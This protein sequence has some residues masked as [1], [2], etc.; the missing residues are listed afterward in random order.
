MKVFDLKYLTSAILLVLTF[1]YGVLSTHYQW[2]PYSYMLA[3][4]NH[5][6]PSTV[7][8]YAPS[9][10]YLEKKSL[11]ENYTN[12]HFDV[13]FIG[14]S[15]TD[16]GHWQEFFSDLKIAN[17]GIQGDMT[18]GVLERLDIIPAGSQSTV[19]LMIGINDLIRERPVDDVFR[20]YQSIVKD[21]VSK[22]VRVYIQSC[23]FTGR[24][25][26]LLNANI[27]ALNTKLKMFAES[28]DRVTF[29]DLNQYLAPLSVL[30][31][32]YTID[33]V[34]LNGKGYLVWK[35]AIQHYLNDLI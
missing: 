25:R 29:I 3:I 33:G 8:R 31:P 16:N 12:R 21:L 30:D 28:I 4:K 17:R 6:Y 18:I 5:L 11:F 24:N 9:T 13:F 27:T 14:D 1:F 34:H 23:L 19:F 35:N 10:Y 15:L 2:F 32:Q 26:A 22:K 7:N 20:D